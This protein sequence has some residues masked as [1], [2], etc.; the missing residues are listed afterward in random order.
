MKVLVACE[1]SQR[2]CNAFRDKGHEAYSCDIIE[3]S[4]NHP[5]WHI[6][7]DCL[8]ILNGNCSFVTMD[9]K[10]H[11]I[12][13]KWDLIIAHPP[14]TD[15]A[16]SGARWFKEK[17]KD[18]RQQKAIDFFMKITNA[19]CDHMAIENPVCIM[20]RLWRKP[21]QIIQPFQF[22]HPVRKQTCLWLKG[23]PELKPT[24]IVRTKEDNNGFS[25]GGALRYARDENGK[26]LPWNDPRT[27]KERSK[28][29][30]GI[31]YAMA[32]QWG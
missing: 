5:E 27:A 12:E 24:R 29:F 30:V 14:C 32:D 17:R 21:D 31:A 19:D 1:E 28:T 13:G 11:T 26:I 25:Y 18:G 7:G 3:C 16:V 4:G 23:L 6:K 8:P 10:E 22:G 15:L 9:N 2:V 20:S